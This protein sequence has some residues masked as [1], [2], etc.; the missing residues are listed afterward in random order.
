MNR[1]TIRKWLK[2]LPKMDAY[3]DKLGALIKRLRDS[4]MQTTMIDAFEAEIK[5]L[6]ALRAAIEAE[7]IN[8]NETYQLIYEMKYEQGR[9]WK[10][11]PYL[12]ED[13]ELASL[14]R[15]EQRMVD[16]IN[17]LFQKYIECA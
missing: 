9:E 6:T 10:E 15:F 7:F 11:L 12:I 1:Q 2:K 13:Y 17:N 5:Q 16:E 8:M 3:M 14:Q 4:G